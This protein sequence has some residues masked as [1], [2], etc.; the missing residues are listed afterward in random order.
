MTCQPDGRGTSKYVPPS[1]ETRPDS[2][3]ETAWTRSLRSSFDKMCDT[4]VF[5]GAS[6]TKSA[7]ANSA[8][9]LTPCGLLVH[10]HLA[11][12]QVRYT[13]HVSRNGG[14]SAELL[15][16]LPCDRRC[17]QCVSASYNM[18]CVDELI[19]WRVVQVKPTGTDSESVIDVIVTI[20]R[21]ENQYSGLRDGR[22]TGTTNRPGRLDAKD[23]MTTETTTTA[24]PRRHASLG[25]G[26][27]ISMTAR[28]STS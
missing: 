21:R 17:R 18:Y 15:D 8:V 26:V 16:R 11:C 23:T 7:D 19:G 6:E 3:A 9:R 13:R 14:G 12:C 24:N 4:C 28:T 10:L 1:G 20:E 25:V 27:A 5:T 22:V 2:S